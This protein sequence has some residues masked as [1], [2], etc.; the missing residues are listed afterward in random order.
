MEKVESEK[1]TGTCALKNIVEFIPDVDTLL[2]LAPEELGRVLLR[3]AKENLQIDQFYPGS[4]LQWQVS[5]GVAPYP[6]NRRKEVE[7]ALEEGWQWLRI[8]LLIVPAPGTNGA[9]GYA[10]FSRRG[11]QLVND[12]KAFESY[13]QAAAF[14]KELLHPAIADA[15]WIELARS[16]FDTAAFNAFKAVE[17]AVRQA[18]R[19]EPTDV[20]VAL[21]RKAFHPDN[22]PLSDKEQPVAERE[23]LMH[24]FAGAIGSYK[25]PHSHRTVSLTDHREAQ[26]MVL[27]ASHLLRI[28]DARAKIKLN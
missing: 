1:L 28:V 25:N 18:A 27:L 6:P 9:N 11:K 17:V 13:R 20:G 16:N 8:H 10:I 15:V 7:V 22:G 5:S 21:M 3:V 24:L 23:A 14:P 19:L 26:E 12:D 4:E 2:A